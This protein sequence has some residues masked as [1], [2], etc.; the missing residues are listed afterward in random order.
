MSSNRYLRQFEDTEHEKTPVK[1]LGIRGF[2]EDL[3][4]PHKNDLGIYDDVIVRCIGEETI[5]F[6]ASTDPG[7]YWIKHPMNPKGCAILTEA[8]HLFKLGVHQ[9]KYPALVQAEDFVVWRLDTDGNRKKKGN[10]VDIHI[11]SGG[12]GMDVGSFSAGCQV[13]QSPEGYFQGTWFKFFDPLAEAMH[14]YGQKTVPY[15]LMFVEDL[16]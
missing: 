15:K 10:A 12:P 9:Q 3:G 14:R 7:W 1:L 11:H 5:G 13:I 2:Y 4:N 6:R 16:K 8:T